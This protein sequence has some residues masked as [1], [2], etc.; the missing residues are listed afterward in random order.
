MKKI[1]LLLL[2]L[3][4]S[5]SLFFLFS[6]NETPDTNDKTEEEGDDTQGGNTLGEP[7]LVIFRYGTSETR[8][9]EKWIIG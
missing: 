1:L 3:S 8:N 2:L 6:C 9:L 5:F 7:I 4:L